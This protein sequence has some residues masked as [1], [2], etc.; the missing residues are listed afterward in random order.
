MN[1]GLDLDGQICDFHYSFTLVANRLF[2]CPIIEDI[3]EVKS[4]NWWD[5]DYPLT[6]EQHKLVWKEID[7][8][9]EDFWFNLRSLIDSKVFQ[10]LKDLELN[11]H[12]I[13]FITARRNTAGKTALAQTTAWIKKHS[14]LEHF[15]VIPT[16]KKGQVLDALKMDYFLDDFPEHLISATLKAPKCKSFLLIRPYNNY[17][18]EFFK[19]SNKYKNVDFVYSVDEFL[20]IIENES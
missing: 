7:K 9:I 20:T 4:Y 6:K 14:S 5:W 13:Y 12:N 17:A 8:N 11:N 19:K 18:I 1:I 3:N 10:R 16:E 15:S 2:G